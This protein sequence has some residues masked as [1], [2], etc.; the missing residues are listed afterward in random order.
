MSSNFQQTQNI[1]LSMVEEQDPGTKRFK[2]IELA[3]ALIQFAQVDENELQ[4]LLQADRLIDWFIEYKDLAEGLLNFFQSALRFLNEEYGTEAFN[5]KMKNLNEQLSLIQNQSEEITKN[6][7]ELT[8][9]KKDLESADERLKA[10]E[11]ESDKLRAIYLKLQP[12]NI[13]KLS[14]SIRHPIEAIHALEQDKPSLY[15]ARLSANQS[16]TEAIQNSEGVSSKVQAMLALSKQIEQ[17][18]KNYDQAL[19]EIITEKEA[20]VKKIRQLNMTG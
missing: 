2:M 5:K 19:K 7:S 11:H 20:T 17:Y 1:W 9:K 10:L 8:L 4:N 16:I 14:Q 3:K 13:D 6:I 12:E 15:Q 18:L